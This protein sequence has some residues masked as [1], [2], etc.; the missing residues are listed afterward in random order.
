MNKICILNQKQG[1]DQPKR[2]IIVHNNFP[3][4]SNISN[5]R[6]SKWIDRILN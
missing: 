5:H 3:P 6:S 2:M 4:I 1:C